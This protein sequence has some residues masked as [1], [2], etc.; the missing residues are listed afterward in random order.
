MR[1]AVASKI[2]EIAQRVT[3]SEGMELVE[4]EIK[5]GGNQRLVRISIDK[6]AGITHADCE[7]VSQQVGTILDVED[8]M[9]GGRYTLE[10]S[11]P[12]VER[13]LLKPHDYE[14]FQGKK[15]KVTL[16]EAIDGRR[17]WEG[18]LAGLSEDAAGRSVALEVGPGQTVRFPF[19]QVLK[20][21]LKFEW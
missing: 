19:E 20:A 4:V 15:V 12:G 1:E 3:E 13:K 9:P 8:V 6:P 21:N 2:E 17:T 11:S 16:R 14:R 7:L 18:T 10:V 5:G